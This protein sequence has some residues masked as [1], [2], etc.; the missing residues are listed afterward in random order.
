MQ[1]HSLIMLLN[2]GSSWQDI[3]KSM[4]FMTYEG[5][6]ICHLID[7]K[8]YPVWMMLWKLLAKKRKSPEFRSEGW[9][10]QKQWKTATV[11]SKCHCPPPESGEVWVPASWVEDAAVLVQI[12]WLATVKNPRAP[13]TWAAPCSCHPS[14]FSPHRRGWAAERTVQTA[15]GLCSSGELRRCAS[16][17]ACS[18]TYHTCYL[19]LALGIWSVFHVV[20]ALRHHFSHASFLLYGSHM[21]SS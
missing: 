3:E 14:S 19:V 13:L 10:L 7:E 2:L 1:S 18:L 6:V 8:I 15:V 20:F 11:L 16:L 17:S 12:T 9:K 4:K 5:N 21:P